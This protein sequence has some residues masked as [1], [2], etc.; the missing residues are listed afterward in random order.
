MKKLLYILLF[1][2]LFAIAQEQDPCFSVND[3]ISFTEEANPTITKN[4]VGGWNMFGF[5]CSQEIDVVEAFSSIIDKVLLVKTNNGSVYMP[6]YGFNGIGLLVGGEGYQIKMVNTVYGFSFCE[7]IN[8]QNVEG[9]TDCEASNFNKLASLDD[10]SCNYD[11]DGDGINDA[12]EV[13]GCQDINACNYVE[14]ATN[15][16]DCEFPEEGY[17]CDDNLLEFVLGEFKYGGI[18]YWVDTSNKRALVAALDDFPENY[19]ISYGCNL[20]CDDTWNLG[21]GN[22]IQCAS[23]DCIGCGL[24]NTLDYGQSDSLCEY[25]TTASQIINLD[26]NGYNDWFLPS[27]DELSEM[28]FSIGLGSINLGELHGSY[29]T[30]SDGW[31]FNF[32]LGA[33]ANSNSIV[34]W[35][36]N[37]S[38][39][40]KYRP[41]RAVGNWIEGCG[42]PFACNYNPEVNLVNNS[43]CDIPP[44]YTEGL[45]YD[46]D[47]IAICYNENACNYHIVDYG[48]YYYNNYT[49]CEYPE[50]GYD[51]DGNI[52]AEIGDVM[53]GGYLFYKDSSNTRGLVAAIEDLTI[54]SVNTGSTFTLTG[55][56][57]YGY[58]WG[59]WQE[60]VDGADETFIG[61]GYQ[62]TLD[63]LNYGC[64][65]EDSGT[66]PA[67]A[68]IEYESN[69]YSDWYLP[70]S[71]ELLEMVQN[72]GYNVQNNAAGFVPLL[73]WSSSEN[74]NSNLWTDGSEAAWVVDASSGYISSHPKYVYLNHNQARAIRAFGNWIEGCTDESA[75]NYNSEVNLPN[76]TLCE[77]PQEGFNCDGNITAQIGD[78]MEG[79]Y[80]FYI[81]ETGQHGLVAALEDLEGTYEWGCY[82]PEFSGTELSGADGTSIGTGYQNTVDIVAECSESPIAA[83]EALAYIS[84]G[85]NDWYLPSKDELIEMYNIIGDGGSEGNI[86]GFESN[87]WPYYNYWSSTEINSYDAW[88]VYFDSGYGNSAKNFP[89]SVR[90]IR[91]FGDWTM[92]CMDETACNYNPDVNLSNSTLCEYPEQG[93]DCEGNITEYVVGMLA[94][95]GIVFYVDETGEHGLVAAMEDIGQFEWGC[96]GASI[97]GADGTTLGTGYQNTLDIVTGCSETPTAASEVLAYE[98]NGFDDWYLPSKD[99][100]LEMYSTIGQG[101]ID[102]NIGDFNIGLY[103]SSS[104]SNDLQAFYVSFDVGGGS[105]D[106]SKSTE[107][108]VRPIRSF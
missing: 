45:M 19:F 78:I 24:Q 30:S 102:G 58:E 16:G 99:E 41:I 48:L 3:F 7:S 89:F 98:S 25:E 104:E 1:V 97:S 64:L 2:P 40:M 27:K 57:V 35:T 84:D 20:S 29:W 69:G 9:C 71:G 88:L 54:G 94:E 46:C 73:Y 76:S 33:G 75:C 50:Q 105:N 34:G 28:L 74:N 56:Y 6:E 108:F 63:I 26:Y 100:L 60:H 47:G 31:W 51:C 101:G 95:G 93:Y 37:S 12:D 39:I 8:W 53:E 38:F 10:G 90:P 81:D 44:S 17:D 65:V 103:W 87:I 4:F 106:N 43:L 79:G 21:S 86:G 92:G 52:T 18:V 85:Y 49:E 80:L 96:Y 55:E 70:S 23:S 32:G 68:S 13:L 72:I 67:Q 42:N 59:C 77:Y 82:E 14:I 11:S 36:S 22:P 107:D 83:S 91:A 5:P 15:Q 61:S 62:N 66:T